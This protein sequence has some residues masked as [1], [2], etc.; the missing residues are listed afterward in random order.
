[1]SAVPD[2]PHPDEPPPG[3]RP[4]G[5]RPRLRLIRWRKV[6]SGG[7]VVGF[8]EVELPSGL[9]I[10]DVMVVARHGANGRGEAWV[11]LPGMPRL[12]QEGG[13]HRIVRGADGKPVYDRVLSWRTREL[14]EAFSARV[15]ELVRAEHPADLPR[16]PER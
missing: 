6:K 11:N 2:E 5:E 3:E 4:L 14:A 1:M 9:R 13:V 12:R 7:A 15:I 10:V 8:A 16:P